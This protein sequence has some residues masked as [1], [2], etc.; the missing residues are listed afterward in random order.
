MK[1][2]KQNPFLSSNGALTLRGD[3]IPPV[4]ARPPYTAP[5]W[6]GDYKS[7]SP[8]YT[9]LPYDESIMGLGGM[10]GWMDDLSYKINAMTPTT[11]LLGMAGLVVGGAMIYKLVIEK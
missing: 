9:P 8:Y 6:S 7:P 1:F 11:K 3:G 4:L 5:S 2:R 10:G